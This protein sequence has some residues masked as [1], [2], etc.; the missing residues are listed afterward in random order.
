MKISEM[1]GTLSGS[2]NLQTDEAA[3]RAKSE[4]ALDYDGCQFLYPRVRSILNMA[5]QEVARAYAN[6][7]QPDLMERLTLYGRVD[8]AQADLK[9]YLKDCEKFLSNWQKEEL[10]KIADDLEEEKSAL[11]RQGGAADIQSLLQILGGALQF[12]RMNTPRMSPAF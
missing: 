4:D 10:S 5:L 3:F 11:L 12:F 1:A 7:R 9:Q 6:G 8:Q 2:R